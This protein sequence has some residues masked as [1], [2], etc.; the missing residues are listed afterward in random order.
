MQ[1]K[2]LLLACLL[3]GSAQAIDYSKVTLDKITI[4]DASTSNMPGKAFQAATLMAAPVARLCTII[5]DYA[6]YPS[7]MP[8]V[9]KAQ[10]TRTGDDFSVVDMTLDLPLGKVKK[11][12]LRL[13]PK[14]ASQSCRLSW[15][16][17]P[18]EEV[19]IEDTIADTSGYWQLSA[20][21]ADPSK[22]IVEYYV[23]ADPGLVPFGFRWI[24]DMMSERSL[25]KTLEA[26]RS[27]AAQ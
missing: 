8:N 23:Y 19:K 7:F 9:G 21:P 14:I 10:V 20:S 15:K 27:K 13:E 18:W 25:P 26:V 2:P 5:Q 6:D 12:R 17:L 3:A 4:V 22:T 1:A 11:Y 16:Q 24:V